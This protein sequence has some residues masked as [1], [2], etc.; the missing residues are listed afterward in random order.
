MIIIG[1]LSFVILIISVF[2]FY[3]ANQIKLQKDLER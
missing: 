2:L 1:I 3:N